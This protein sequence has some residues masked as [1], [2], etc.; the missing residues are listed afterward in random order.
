MIQLTDEEIKQ[1]WL[2]AEQAMGFLEELTV[3]ELSGELYDYGNRIHSE[4]QVKAQLKKVA[5]LLEAHTD[6]RTWS[7]EN[8]IFQFTVKEWQALLEEVSDAPE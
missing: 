2:K 1:A 3:E 4:F 7:E 8:C 5:D 6:R